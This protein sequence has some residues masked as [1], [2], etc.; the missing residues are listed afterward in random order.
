M[1]QQCEA[2]NSR[3]LE[4]L[5]QMVRQPSVAAQGTGIE[6]TVALVT[7]LIE[8][9]GGTVRVLRDGVPGNP[10]IYAEFPGA[11]D[12]T[13]LF[14]DH[15][16][17]QPA[18]PFDEWTTQ[19]FG[20]EVKDGK[21]YGRGVADN[22]G[23]IAARLAAIR[24]VRAANGGTLPCRVKFL[25][26]GEEEI[27]SPALY[28]ALARYAD[29][30]AADAC[31]WEFGDTDREHRPQLYGGVKG[32]AY[33]QAW[34]RHADVDMHSSLAAVVENPAWRLTWAL[35]TLKAPDGRVLV[36]G[37]YDD[38]TEPTP[39]QR[40]MARQIPFNAE[41]MKASYGIKWPLLADSHDEAVDRL[42][43]QPTCT[44]CGL[45]AGYTGQ[46][47]KTVL[48]KRAQAKIDCRLVPGQDPQ[49]ILALF[50]QHLDQQGFTDVEL[51]LLSGQRAYW[52]DPAHPFVDLVV[53]T[54]RKA[55]GAEPVYHL[56]SA[57]T[58]PMYGFGR[59]LNALPIVSTGSGN[60]GSRA[61]APDEN[62][63]LADFHNAIHH[64]ALLL[65]AF[66]DTTDH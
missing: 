42:V 24:A 29:L 50:R 12:R 35:A 19:P 6:E 30:F 61:H 57:G 33:I 1:R 3:A 8:A 66:G 47:S 4:E 5:Q 45:E 52:T 9:S 26:E 34:V 10:V 65:Q 28:P 58:G 18:E 7:K 46:G 21:V 63:R 38:I 49:R 25:I 55:F 15:Y 59:Y 40:E 60:F 41:G 17:V 20:G 23:E 2:E 56:S 31:I 14:Y 16:D 64:M 39:A 48:P 44:I 43:F 37:F 54:A 22:K 62:I 13:L 27:G 11:S 32:M 53:K 51:E 36:P